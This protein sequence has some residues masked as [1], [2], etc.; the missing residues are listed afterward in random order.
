MDE[1]GLTFQ[2]SMVSGSGVNEGDE[3]EE[4]MED[5]ENSEEDGDSEDDDE[6]WEDEED[7]N[8]DHHASVSDVICIPCSIKPEFLPIRLLEQKMRA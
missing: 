8:E 7:G 2:T 5:D 4:D 3:E 1:D 6:D